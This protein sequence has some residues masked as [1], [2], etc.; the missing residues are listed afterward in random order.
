MQ[1]WGRRL[2]NHMQL[3][4]GKV[5]HGYPNKKPEEKGKFQKPLPA[6]QP[7]ANSM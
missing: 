2:Q 6:P 3:R 7:T 1:I 4:K 5:S